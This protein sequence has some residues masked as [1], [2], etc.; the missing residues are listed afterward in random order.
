[1]SEQKRI[2][3]NTGPLISLEKI[4][5]RGGY[6][7]MRQLYAKI[8]IPPAVLDELAQGQFPTPETY[9]EHYNIV[10]LVEVKGVSLVRSFPEE[11]RLDEGEGKAIRLAL[12]LQLPLLIEETIGGRVAQGLGLQISGA[13][14]QVLK[15]F[16]TRHIGAWSVHTCFRLI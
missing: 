7:V 4:R 10:D 6:D 9:L 1:M 13:A 2:V 11:R 12:E 16:R 15:A 5:G 3:S 8:L 14:G